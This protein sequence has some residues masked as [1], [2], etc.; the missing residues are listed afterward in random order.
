MNANLSKQKSSSVSSWARIE[1]G[2]EACFSRN[3]TAIEFYPDDTEKTLI[4]I[5]DGE[6]EKEI[7]IE[8]TDAEAFLK[9]IIERGRKPE[10]SS[11]SR[12]T[13]CYKTKVEWRNLAFVANETSGIISAFSNEWTTEELEEF[14]PKFKDEKIAEKIGGLLAKGLHRRAIEIYLET[15]RFLKRLSSP[16][17][18]V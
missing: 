6:S 5:S 4:K 8:K 10:V 12:K 13:V 7:F 9:E 15:E 18:K 17:E 14:L 1:I 16:S 2:I 3:Q 11:E